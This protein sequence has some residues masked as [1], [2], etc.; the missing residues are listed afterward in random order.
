MAR[1]AVRRAHRLDDCVHV[2]GHHR[3]GGELNPEVAEAPPTNW[4]SLSLI[5]AGLLA[6]L[7]LIGPLGFTIAATV[8]FT[9]VAAAF[10]SRRTLRDVLIAFLVALGS[11]LLFARLL[12]VNIGGG[13]VERAVEGLLGGPA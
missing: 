8:Q 3:D 11:Y 9:L 13:V 10:G 6:N 2:V 5:G 12:G 4:R 1:P 7:V